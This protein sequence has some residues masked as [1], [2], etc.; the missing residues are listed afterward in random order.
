MCHVIKFVIPKKATK[1]N[2]IFIVDLT[3]TTWCQIDGE[4][5]F[6]FCG[7]L[8]K[9]ELYTKKKPF[10]NLAKLL[11][12]SKNI[13]R[14]VKISWCF[15]VTNKLFFLFQN[16]NYTKIFYTKV[17]YICPIVSILTKSCFLSLYFIS[18]FSGRCCENIQH[19]R[20]RILV[21]RIWSLP[22]SYASPW[23][24]SWIY[25]CWQQRYGILLP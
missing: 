10:G 19:K 6:N 2:E 12:G 13:R 16:H 4:D 17:F 9:H 20:R 25:C 8:R 23:K 7:L 1:I 22:N 11:F 14:L 21:Q 24:C 18:F 5:F 3:L 15:D